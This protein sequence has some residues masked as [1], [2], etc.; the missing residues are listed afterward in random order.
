MK[1]FITFKSN[2]TTKEL[3][4]G[5]VNSTADETRLKQFFSVNFP[6]RTILKVRKCLS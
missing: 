1:F 6:N 4:V 3:M 2:N 5:T